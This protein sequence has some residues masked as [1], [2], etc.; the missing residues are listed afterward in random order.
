[1]SRPSRI[2]R[3]QDSEIV[4]FLVY[5]IFP[6]LSPELLSSSRRSISTKRYHANLEDVDIVARP[7]PFVSIFFLYFSSSLHPQSKGVPADGV[8]CRAFW[9]GMMVCKDGERYAEPAERQCSATSILGNFNRCTMIGSISGLGDGTTTSHQKTHMFTL[10]TLMIN[11][12]LL[13]RFLYAL[14]PCTSPCNRSM[15]TGKMAFTLS[16]MSASKCRIASSSLI[17]K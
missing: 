6:C 9:P 12:Y 5:Q 3:D 4:S 7:S 1:M 11:P 16:P 10:R 2:F 14:Q 17:S 15:T 13:I 8:G